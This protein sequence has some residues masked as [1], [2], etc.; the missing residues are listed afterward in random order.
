[1]PRAG[2]LLQKEKMTL[3]EKLKRMPSVSIEEIV[4]KEYSSVGHGFFR[5][6]M[7]KDAHETWKRGEWETLSDVADRLLKRRLKRR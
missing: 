4:E 3:E 6:P 2:T 5:A 7:P 1:M